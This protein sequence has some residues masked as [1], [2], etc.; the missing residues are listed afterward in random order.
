MLPPRSS[1][2]KALYRYRDL[3]IIALKARAN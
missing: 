3:A 1:S 2:P